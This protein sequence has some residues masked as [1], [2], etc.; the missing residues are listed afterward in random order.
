MV[1]DP[2]FAVRRAIPSEIADFAVAPFACEPREPMSDDEAEVPTQPPPALCVIDGNTPQ[3][4]T[5][6]LAEPY[7]HL[8]GVFG[9]RAIVQR[10]GGSLGVVDLAA[11]GDEP[12][13]VAPVWTVPDGVQVT[14][15]MRPGV[16]MALQWSGRALSDVAV[17]RP[18]DPLVRVSLPAGVER[19]IF[20]DPSHGYA[21]SRSFSVLRRTRDGGRTWEALPSPVDGVYPTEQDRSD[22]LDDRWRPAPER[23]SLSR[24]VLDDRLVVTGWGPIDD[25]SALAFAVAPTAPAPETPRAAWFAEGTLPRLQCA[26]SAL[27]PPLPPIGA[28][29]APA[30]RAS[31]LFSGDTLEGSLRA[32]TW[33][34]ASG[35]LTARFAWVG[36][37]AQGPYAAASRAASVH[38]PSL[39]WNEVDLATLRIEVLGVDRGAASVIAFREDHTDGELLRVTAAGD[40][41]HLATLPVRDLGGAAR[42][43]HGDGFTLLSGGMGRA[44][45]FDVSPGGAGRRHRSVEPDHRR[46]YHDD[47]S[48]TARWAIAESGPQRGAARLLDGTPTEVAVYPVAP[49][50]DAEPVRV[51]WRG[52]APLVPCRAPAAPDAWSVVVRVDAPVLGARTEDDCVD[53]VVETSASGTC[54]RGV[55]QRSAA[56]SSV[57]SAAG[58]GTLRGVATVGRTAHALEC[59]LP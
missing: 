20:A 41:E 7:E 8:V 6:R 42:R 48:E 22:I 1:S 49:S 36:R 31:R 58:D 46:N 37:D 34:D 14:V 10:D 11:R 9:R 27:L 53:L 19:A 52:D 57:V 28:L 33:R 29:A 44:D 21:W 35:R 13:P 16:V 15:G 50:P 30:G 54:L 17:G 5:R 59:R 43:A 56:A 45:V 24:C 32:L 38:G 40:V 23:C 55:E 18:G 26:P 4:R 47:R 25:P 12:L 3:G 39:E 2:P 51:R